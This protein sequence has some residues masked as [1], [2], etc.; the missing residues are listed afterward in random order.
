MEKLKG[1]KWFW[2]EKKDDDLDLDDKGGEKKEKKDELLFSKADIDKAAQRRQ[3]ALKRA[4]K[5]EDNNKALE[6]KLATMPDADEF[7]NLN[8]D[9]ADLK[10][11]LKELQE[12]K[13]DADLQ[14]ID[15]ERER[16]KAKMEREFE[17]ERKA[18]QKKMDAL[19]V[20][21]DSFQQEKKQ[22]LDT[23]DKF[24]QS[25]LENEIISIAAPKAFNPRQI[26]KLIVDDFEFDET[27]D[28]WYKN[29]Y[30][31]KGKISAV[32]S[33]D[34]YVT[35][36]LTDKDNENLLKADIK[37]GSD[38][39]RGNQHDRQD[40]GP[41]ADQTPTDQMYKWAEMS[42]LDVNVKSTAE[43]KTWLYNT[44]TRLHSKQQ[45]QPS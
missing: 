38:T 26:V 1:L 41:P 43:D 45:K 42:G 31:A 21:V 5:A 34:E 16:A 32:L 10:S 2:E 35:T 11:Q 6:A 23:L 9:Y 30:D 39:P 29:V 40:D 3:A 15:D 20:Q 22:H 12:A 4:R 25:S 37:R 24:R 17:K 14:K 33:V 8:K 28:K 36:F 18:L 44:Y 13:A 7:D 19:N 27:D